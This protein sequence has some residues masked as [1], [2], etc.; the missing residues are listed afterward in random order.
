MPLVSCDEDDEVA[1]TAP[2]TNPF[3]LTEKVEVLVD[4]LGIPHIYGANEEDVFLIQGYMTAHDRL[5]QLDRRRREAHG[6]EAEAFGAGKLDADRDQRRYNFT[7]IAEETEAHLRATVPDLAELGDAYAAGVNAYINDAVAMRNEASLNAYFDFYDYTPEPWQ[8][9][10]T[11]V[12]EK[13]FTRLLG[14][15]AETEAFLGMFRTLVDDDLYDDFLRYDP[16]D[17][18]GFLTDFW[19]DPT[20]RT[21]PAPAPDPQRE[22]LRNLPLETQKALLQHF[23]DRPRKIFGSNNWAVAPSRSASG[24]AMLANDTHMGLPEPCEWYFVHLNTAERGGDLDSIGVSYPGV[25]LVLLGHNGKVSWGATV[26]IYDSADA[27]LETRQGDAVELDG[28][29]VPLIQRDETILVRRD[30]EAYGSNDTEMHTVEE[31]PHRGPL[32]SPPLG[33]PLSISF[34]W[35]GLEPRSNFE[36]YYAM[37]HADT[38]QMGRD[39]MDKLVC[40]GMNWVMADTS[41]GIGYTS[42]VAL[43]VREA[44]DPDASPL[45]L[46]DGRG[47]FDWLAADDP[48]ALFGFLTV[49]RD[50]IPWSI[51]PAGGVIATANNDISGITH[52]NDPFNE[53]AYI[54]GLF[55]HGNRDARIHE[56]L[57]A[58]ATHTLEDMKA[59]QMDGHSRLAEFFV[60]FLL[61]AAGNRPDLV[62]DARM[63]QAL[64][65]LRQW[66]YGTGRE[67]I[68][69]TLFH[70]WMPLLVQK[71]LGDE[72]PLIDEF[73]GNMG[74]GDG[75]FVIK[76]VARYLEITAD[77]I[78]EIEAGTLPFPNTTGTNPFDDTATPELET[79]DELLMTT[80]ADAL[81]GIEE[82]M[83]GH[84]ASPDDLA[85]WE[86]GKWHI[87]RLEDFSRGQ[88]AGS[89]EPRR[90][91]PGGM[92]TVNCM[93]HNLLSNGELLT[94]NLVSNAA[95]MRFVT[96]MA[97]GA[98][99]MEGMLAG[100]QSERPGDRH[101][102]DQIE[103]YINGDF[104]VIPFYRNEVE[105]RA[106]RRLIF[107]VGYPETTVE[108]IVENF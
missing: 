50:F 22:M 19:Q 20:R 79:R 34:R 62:A 92:Y 6:T 3:V 69:S 2:P 68:G 82:V 5:F 91:A 73:I 77:T 103:A 49:A 29:M 106:A 44:I 58:K 86:W 11:L 30:G 63:G 33:L 38:V 7:G 60:P 10:D 101:Y 12:V 46:V 26:S 1:A 102:K 57:A 18:S 54:G 40:G 94:D 74:W 42:N 48:N 100:G 23:I 17:P 90:A 76:S 13:E 83:A 61:E 98:V 9:S 41:G 71:T 27:Y 31:V 65:I 4:D 107:P 85:T 95:S 70:G 80:F 16:M 53:A 108:V 104:Q 43:P 96:E 47:G 45:G 36:S 21:A 59:L 24:H 39:A 99:R 14:M 97:P 89:A 93:N 15:Q 105:A 64:E 67:S 81:D 35:A 75:A 78:E 72:H 84:G 28:Q 25:P 66:D 37:N 32:L 88:V 52:D 51:N 8:V 87:I 56:V 55:A